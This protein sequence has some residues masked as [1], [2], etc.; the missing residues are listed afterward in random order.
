MICSIDS[1]ITSAIIFINFNDL[2]SF[3]I[4]RTRIDLNTLIIL[5]LE[6]PALLVEI[7]N[8]IIDMSAIPNST[9]LNQSLVNF[10]FIM[11]FGWMF[12]GNYIL[13][14]LFIAILLNG[15]SNYTSAGDGSFIINDDQLISKLVVSEIEKDDIKSTLIKN[16]QIELTGSLTQSSSR[17]V[18]LAET[19]AMTASQHKNELNRSLDNL[20]SDQSE[21]LS[22][23]IYSSADIKPDYYKMFKKPKKN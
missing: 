16:E 17:H 6:T 11:T 22:N 14:N 7:T 23:E 1:D 2:N 10:G 3:V 20:Q 5:I 21:K 19:F 8:S 9:M 15:F 4:L 18:G 13:L 12:I